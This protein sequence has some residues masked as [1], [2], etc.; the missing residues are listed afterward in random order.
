M[1][2]VATILA[3][4]AFGG[5]LDQP[6]APAPRAAATAVVAPRR[7]PA[8][9]PK[10]VARR[11]GQP[12]AIRR[13]MQTSEGRASVESTERM[14]AAMEAQA[15]LDRRRMAAWLR[16]MRENWERSANERPG[17][18]QTGTDYVGTYNGIGAGSISNG[19]LPIGR[20]IV[21]GGNFTIPQGAA[22]GQFTVENRTGPFGE[23]L[24][25][26]YNAATGTVSEYDFSVSLP[27]VYY[28]PPGDG[29]PPLIPNPTGVTTAPGSG[30]STGFLNNPSLI[31][32]GPFGRFREPTSNIPVLNNL[33]P[34]LPAMAIPPSLTGTY[35]PGIPALSLP[36][37]PGFSGGGG[38]PVISVS[39]PPGAAGP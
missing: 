18:T 5:P 23:Q 10:A 34:S 1:T 15:E 24:S 2:W 4:F 11:P 21:P 13:M 33:N 6:T 27:P 36:A 7:P 17:Q 30:S 8:A 3:G 37:T 28:G 25:R 32:T 9:L 26:V 16:I 14:L 35:G 39:P 31:D 22:P 29:S 20:A 19:G 12:S 38:I